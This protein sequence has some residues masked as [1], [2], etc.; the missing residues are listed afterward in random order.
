MNLAIV[1]TSVLILL[2]SSPGPTEAPEIR[3]RRER[4]ELAIQNIVKQG[5][6][7][8]VPTPVVAELA[9]AGQGSEVARKLIGALARRCRFEELDLE[10]ADV[11]GTIRLKALQKRKA[12]EERGAISYDALI[13]A[14]AHARRA[15]WL[16]TAN[17]RDFSALLNEVS[18]PV[19]LVVTDTVPKSGQLSLVHQVPTPTPSAAQLA[20]SADVK[21]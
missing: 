5:A 17:P 10:A 6:R 2:L 18:S 9:K 11:A 16:L 12:G 1:D 14:I 3:V 15:R 8:A 7:L 4:T 21:D 19:E 13:V 20:G